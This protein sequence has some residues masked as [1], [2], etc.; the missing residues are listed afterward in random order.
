MFWCDRGPN[1]KEQRQKALK[2]DH[3]KC[4]KCGKRSK[5]NDTLDVHHRRAYRLFNG[6]YV[7]ANDLSNLVSLCG[8]CHSQVEKSLMGINCPPRV[9]TGKSKYN[10][11]SVG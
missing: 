10:P 9:G 2:R 6:D 7:A 11:Y 8:S 1:W 5:K 3:Y 4:V